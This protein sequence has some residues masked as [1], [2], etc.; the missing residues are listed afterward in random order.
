M[1]AQKF[2]S[3]LNMAKERLNG[4]QGQAND[5]TKEV[6]LLESRCKEESRI[7]DDLKGQLSEKSNALED[8]LRHNINK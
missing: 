4:Q 5:L 3:E 2:E 7:N 1:K 8:A 6:S